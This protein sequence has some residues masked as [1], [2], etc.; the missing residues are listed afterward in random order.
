ML[1]IC[2]PGTGAMMPLPNRY[3]AS[4]LVRRE[5]RLCLV[6]CG[7][8]TQ[9]AVRAAGWSLARIDT[10]CITH[11]H[12][13]H[14]AG[15]PGLL[16]TMGTCGRTRPVTLMGPKGLAL[17]TGCLRVIAPELPFPLEFQEFD[18]DT[19]HTAF[20]DMSLTAFSLSHIIPCYGYSFTLSRPGQFQPDK[21]RALGIPVGHWGA[22][23]RG[24]TVETEQGVFLPAMV[25]GPE[26]KGL[27]ITYCTDT[28]PTDAIARHAS[29]ADLFICEGTYGEE[30]K[31]EKADQHG[32]MTFL[33][34]AR[35]ARQAGAKEL[36]LTHFSPA[37]E[38][39]EPYLPAARAIFPAA[40]AGRDGL[41]RVL[42]FEE[43][44]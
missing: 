38:D 43:E 22:L 36:L 14:T 39:P 27:R 12:A 40:S 24:E 11:F 3:L 23:Q 34:A 19:H 35:L 10:I 16:L 21:A 30:E 31:A 18:Q 28:R 2:L 17:V 25:L 9:V 44:G 15:L 1:E 13:D 32:H 4:L 6:D 29:G 20:Q 41:R 7:E 5:G 42:R 8:G 33:D 26:R 37:V